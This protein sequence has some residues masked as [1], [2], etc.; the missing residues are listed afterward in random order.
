[1][2]HSV[3]TD[4]RCA[5]LLIIDVQNDF[6]HEDG[7]VAARNPDA[8]SVQ[9]VVPVI[10]RLIGQARQAGVPVIFI[11]TTH[12]AATSSE[13]WANRTE[14]HRG[15]PDLVQEGA[16]GAQ[17][18]KLVPQEGDII[19][20]K[21]RYSAFSGTELDATLRALGRKSLVITGVATNVCVESTAR[22]G[23][24]REF[25][26][27]LVEDGCAAYDRELELATFRNIERSFGKVV[28]S[29]HIIR[30]WQTGG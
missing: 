17:F 14:R 5:A 25:H 11:R 10:E 28:D 1:M 29:A 9:R 4:V 3:H 19:V 27:T 6:C 15:K 12:S 7:Q 16:W 13:V 20:E 24:G 23:F 26:V 18:Y 30:A 21:H 2:I 8:V 22:E